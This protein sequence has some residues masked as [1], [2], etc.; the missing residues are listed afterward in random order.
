MKYEKKYNFMLIL[1]VVIGVQTSLFFVTN[2]EAKS[3]K[4]RRQSSC[5]GK[6]WK[7]EIKMLCYG[8]AF[9]KR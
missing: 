1:F 3:L 2:V 8:Q 5:N 6:G 7:K 4:K 9:G